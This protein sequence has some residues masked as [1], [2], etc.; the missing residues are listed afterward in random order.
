MKYK[1]AK[2]RY[3]LV[4]VLL[5]SLTFLCSACN[6]ALQPQPTQTPTAIVTIIPT[7]TPNPTPTNSPTATN[8]LIPTATP[9]IEATPT[10]GAIINIAQSGYSFHKPSGYNVDIS[11]SLVGITDKEYTIGITLYGSTT[12]PI[13]SNLYNAADTFLLL[14]FKDSAG[15]FKKENAQSIMIDSVEGLIFDI[16]GSFYDM[17]LK[18]QVVVVN[19]TKTQFFWGIGLAN[20]DQDKNRWE[21]EGLK[22]F[23]ELISSIKFLSKDELLSLPA[24][25]IATDETYG[26]TEANP[27]RVGGDA[28]DGPSRERAYLD[29]LLGPNG[30]EITYERGGSFSF[31][32]TI[33]DT[34][35]ITGFGKTVTLYIDEYSYAAPM[36]P[37]GFTCIYDFPLSEPTY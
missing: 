13:T 8:T 31:G 37:V 34:F 4:F 3:Y 30:E 33:L 16:S 11:G 10:P 2:R 15:E 17:P 14:L 32:D 29:N 26:Y 35:T 18:G 6:V 7:D 36:A 27:I 20:I 28:F 12:L 5:I 9:T 21:D 25:T 23:H 24:C 22:S 19:P 1:S